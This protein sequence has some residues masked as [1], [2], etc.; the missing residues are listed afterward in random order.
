[1]RLFFAVPTTPGVREAVRA[2][3]GAFP[4]RK[5][6]WRWI[7]P[8]N[9]HLTLKFLGEVEERLVPSLHEAAGRITARVAPFTLAFDRFGGFPNLRRPRVIFFAA[10]DGADR[11]RDLASLVED[12]VEPLGFARERRPFRA[13]LTL[14]R[15]KRRLHG[16][17]IAALETI[18]PLPEGT[19]QEVDRFVLMRSHLRRD[20]AQYEEI[21]TYLLTAPR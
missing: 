11:L 1:M 8:E 20:G 5:P 12:E 16:D 14:A 19:A 17:L 7:P 21:G 4:E 9:F 6:P 3:I 18:P 13:H 15:I 10:S 2:A